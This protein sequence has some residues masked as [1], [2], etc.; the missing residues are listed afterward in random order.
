MQKFFV[1]FLLLTLAFQGTLPSE[2]PSAQ[3]TSEKPDDAIIAPS[4]PPYPAVENAPERNESTFTLQ[5][6]NMLATLGLL[7]AL[8][9]GGSWV[10]KRMMRTRM[11]QV[12][13]T[14]TI[15]ILEQR[16]LTAKTLVSVIEIRGKKIGIAESTNGVTLLS[17]FDEDDEQKNLKS[18]EKIL[19]D[20]LQEER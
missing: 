20:K 8:V 18:F 11:L 3:Q 9:L 17:H 5:L 2:P 19:K 16:A 13:E 1:L 15:K 4:V 12:N 6:L 7:L 14:S 10:L